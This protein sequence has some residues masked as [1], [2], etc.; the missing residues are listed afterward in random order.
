MAKSLKNKILHKIKEWQKAR[1]QRKLERI[2]VELTDKNGVEVYGNLSIQS[3]NLDTLAVLKGNKIYVDFRAMRLPDY[4]LKYII[5]HELAHLIIKR[6]TKKFWDIVKQIY[7]EYEKG[8]QMLL[9]LSNKI[10]GKL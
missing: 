4:V 3:A 6:H 2:L 7:P 8:R 10:N 5:A 9:K 1:F